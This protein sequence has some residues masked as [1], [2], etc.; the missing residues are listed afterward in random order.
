MAFEQNDNA[1]NQVGLALDLL[2]GTAYEADLSD[3]QMRLLGFPSRFG[4]NGDNYSQVK[5]RAKLILVNAILGND[6]PEVV[7]EPESDSEPEPEIESQ[8]EPQAEPNQPQTE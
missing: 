3:S 7:A 5:N 2:L 6:L 1:E 8:V 4:N